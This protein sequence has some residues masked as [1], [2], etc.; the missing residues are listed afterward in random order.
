VTLAAL[1]S[2]YHEAD[3]PGGGLRAVLPLAGRTVLERQA[4]LAAAAGAARLVILVER[5]PPTLLAAVDRL[6]SQ[7]LEVVVARSAGEAGEALDPDDRLLVLADGLLPAEAH[8]RR[9]VALGGAAILTVPDV[10]VDDRFERIDAHSRWAGLAI[11]DGEMLRRTAAMVGEWDLQST[12]LRRAIQS[13][14]R[15]LSLRGEPADDMLTVAE[16]AEDLHALQQRIFDGAG[17]HRRDWVSRYLLGYFEREAVRHLMPTSAT[18]A[19]LSLAASLLIALGALAFA[20]HWLG[21]GV[22]LVLLA[23]PFHGAGERLEALRMEDAGEGGWWDHL[24][25][26]LAALALVAL[27][28]AIRDTRGWG[29]L[30]LAGTTIAFALALR[31]EAEGREM[32]GGVWLAEW[33]GLAWLLLPFAAA[34]LW[35]TGLTA[36]AV[37]AGA[38]FFWAQRIV[39]RPA[40]TQSD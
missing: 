14:V 18:P 11:L 31:I 22:A 36:L 26:P 3:E 24:V 10:R 35:G 12:L 7:G 5:V 29:C 4:V 37:Y 15:Q 34:G 8:I 17:A 23:T 19:A 38:S 27:A 33:K 20:S 16:R 30:A 39:H 40:G 32:P 28:L 6:K 2:A 21:T 9:L 13:G 1:I 25:A